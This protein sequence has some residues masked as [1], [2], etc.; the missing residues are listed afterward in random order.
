MSKDKTNFNVEIVNPEED[1]LYLILGISKKRST[2]IAKKCKKSYN[3]LEFFSETIKEVI[4]YMDN[5]N[6]VVFATLC[7]A[8]MHDKAT[9]SV[10]DKLE[11][12]KTLMKLRK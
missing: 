9:N 11:L 5:V 8:R 3:N 2:E 10:N 1:E 6:E 12:L 7:L 4:S